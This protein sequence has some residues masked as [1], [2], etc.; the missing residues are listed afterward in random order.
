MSP[1][2]AAGDP[3]AN[4][5]TDIYSF[6]CT[7]YEMLAGRAPFTDKSPRKLLAAQMSE[8]P[9][10]IDALRP[11]TPALLASLVMQ[12]LQKDPDARRSTRATYFAR[13]TG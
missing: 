9:V 11:D 5:R 8:T 1:E 6:G 13:S 12:C 10:A 2:Q 3:G 4:H 7:A